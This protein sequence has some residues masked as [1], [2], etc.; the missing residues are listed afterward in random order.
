MPRCIDRIW[1]FDWK[2]MIKH[3]VYRDVWSQNSPV[4]ENFL[5]EELAARDRS[6]GLETYTKNALGKSINALRKRCEE[7]PLDGWST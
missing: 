4:L 5:D 3:P 6:Y 1:R 2:K 7:F